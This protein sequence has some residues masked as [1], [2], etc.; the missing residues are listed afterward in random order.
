ML[1]Q[2]EDAIRAICAT[3]PTITHT[4]IKAALA[5]L[6]GNGL[7]EMRG[8]P[9][10]RAYTVAQTS[11]L[12]GKSR[13]TLCDY[14]RRGLLT[15]IYSGAKGARAQGYTGESVA[16]LLSGKVKATGSEVTK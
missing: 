3:D 8:E 13:R 5:E 15:P 4:Q 2:T 7:R 9:P 12:T 16:A 6:S 10:P 11:A 14:A 1:K